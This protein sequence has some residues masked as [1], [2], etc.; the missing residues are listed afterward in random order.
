M[1]IPI[2]I[3]IGLLNEKLNY[4]IKCKTNNKC[5]LLIIYI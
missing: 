3:K 2:N 4:E 1:V 5:I